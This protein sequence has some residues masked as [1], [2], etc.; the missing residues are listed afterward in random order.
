[1]DGAEL[2][3]VVVSGTDVDVELG[4]VAGV[5][6]LSGGPQARRWS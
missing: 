5:R 3:V 2:D 4:S 6:Q 1:V